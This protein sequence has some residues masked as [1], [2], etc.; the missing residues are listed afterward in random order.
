MLKSFKIDYAGIPYKI[1][2]AL[3]LAWGFLWA[4]IFLN[5]F[6]MLLSK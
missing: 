3:V 2:W 1:F 4:V 6:F 5:L